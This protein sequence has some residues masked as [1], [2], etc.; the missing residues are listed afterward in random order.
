M[1]NSRQVLSIAATSGCVGH[2]FLR[3]TDILH[4]G[5]SRQASLGPTEAGAY[6]AQQIEELRP[7][8]VVTEKVLRTS[9]KYKKT[10]ALIAAI[11]AVADMADLEN[12]EVS[13]GR[14]FKDRFAEANDL[15]TRF[16]DMQP[17]VPSPRKPWEAEPRTLIYFE[18]LALVCSAFGQPAASG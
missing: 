14:S 1:S 17:F 3:N 2:V 7:D 12:I 8:W 10:R 18:A 6:A 15:A 4:K 13:R 5:M 11:T 9:K 16:P